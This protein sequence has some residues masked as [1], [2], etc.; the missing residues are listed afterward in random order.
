MMHESRLISENQTS[1]SEGTQRIMPWHIPGA[2]EHTTML[3]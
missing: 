2:D 3:Y 1:S